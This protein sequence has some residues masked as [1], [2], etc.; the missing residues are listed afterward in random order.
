MTR[1]EFT[2]GLMGAGAVSPSLAL[3]GEKVPMEESVDVI[4][5][6]GGP[7]GIAAAI[8]AAKAGASVRL[9]EMHGALGGIWTSGIL[10]CMICFDKSD[11]DRE[12]TRRL[13]EMGA[14]RA[15]RPLSPERAASN[16]IYEPE[17]LKLICESMCEEAKV[18]FLLH[19]AVVGCVRDAGGRR[20]TAVVT[21]SKD[22]RRVWPAKA[23]IDCTGDGDLAARAGCGFD[24]GGPDGSNDQP[25]SLCAVAVSPNREGL[26]RFVVNDPMNFK[27]D[28]T[29][30]VNAKTE[31]HKELVRAGMNPSYSLPTLFEVRDGIYVVMMNHE[32][33]VRV[34]DARQITRST[35]AAR[36]EILMSSLA[37]NRL[38]GAWSGFRVVTTA[39]QLGHR[40]A[41][42]I[43]GR[44]TITTEDVVKGAKFEDAVVTSDFG[45]DV[46][47][48]SKEANRKA[49]YSTMGVKSKPFQIPLRA[50]QAK[51]IDN[52]YMAGRCISGDF[53]PMASYRVTGCAVAMGE[54]VGRAAAREVVSG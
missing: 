25:A 1:R 37:L 4:V 21:E 54:A 35:V 19:T 43:H 41:R 8:A 7:A 24:F 20:L 46:H 44:Y 5:A 11:T 47:A 48:T 52:L 50:C 17:Y 10:G 16:Y 29:P 51:E 42:R 18:D 13:K 49:G 22:G 32:Y 39:E 3:A 9:F 53:V 34:D 36:R 6:G 38:G 27:P 14:M 45:I 15:R 12:I 31:F 30:S 28:G 40:A 26:R 33:G 23:F 2:L